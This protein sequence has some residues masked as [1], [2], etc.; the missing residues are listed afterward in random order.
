M[1]KHRKDLVLGV[2]LLIVA[3]IYY[4]LT[5]SI[6]IFAGLG[7]TWMNSQTTP[8]LYAAILAVLAISLIIRTIRRIK[9]DKDAGLL[10]ESG[11]KMT[12][13]FFFGEY[14]AVILTFVCMF[15][16]AL[17]LKPIGFI[18]SSFVYLIVQIIVL[19]PKGKLTKNVIILALVI[20][21]ITSVLVDWLFV[22]QFSV[23]LPPGILGF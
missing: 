22:T 2:A 18:I 10:E 6:Q 11:E 13:R 4:Y 5:L 23:L 20:A 21:L 1:S 16:Y 14:Y 17:A 19:T 9:A 15:L 3:G 8:Q 12:L 7:A